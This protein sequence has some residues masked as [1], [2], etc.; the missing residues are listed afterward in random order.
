MS[1]TFEESDVP[2]G[3]LSATG[4]FASSVLASPRTQ[5]FPANG[6]GDATADRRPIARTDTEPFENGYHFPPSHGFPQS[7]KLG[8][9][10]FW[11]FFLAPVGFFIVIYGLLV[12][13]WGGM[14]FLLLCNAAPAMCHPSCNDINSARRRWIEYD[15]QVVNALFCVTAFGLAPWRFR[16]L[17]FLLQYR[18][19]GRHGALQRLAGIHRG[20]FRLEGSQHL[21]KSLGPDNVASA[22]SPA[23]SASIPVPP[24][25]IPDA[26]LTGHRA[27]PTKVWKLDLVVWTYVGNTFLQ[28]CLC[29]FMW[30]MNRLDRPGF[31]VGLFVGLACVVAAIGGLQV[32]FEGKRVKGVEGVPLSDADRKRLA[33][34]KE[35]GVPHYNNIKDKKQNPK[36]NPENNR[37]SR[38]IVHEDK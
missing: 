14:L 32:F 11:S 25:A 30:G 37:R 7:F 8:L 6:Q 4:S 23:R 31:A 28:C 16:D 36:A 35:R 10:A 26:P 29:G 17:Y 34:D 18:L 38:D 13:A 12:V 3:F 27:E 24:R 5:S 1:R 2:E 33:L 15:S 19:R 20:W 9:A 22:L 21:D